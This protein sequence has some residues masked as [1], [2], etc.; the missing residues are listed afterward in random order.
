[1]ALTFTPRTGVSLLHNSRVEDTLRT[2]R[3]LELSS[4]LDLHV[5]VGVRDGDADQPALS[6]GLRGRGTILTVDPDASDAGV[7]NAIIAT[8]AEQGSQYA[9]ILR[10]DLT[11]G[12][13]TLGLLT[14]HMTRVPDCGVV[15]AR[16]M[17]AGEPRKVIWSDGATMS[18]TGSLTRASAGL[19]RSKATKAK[20]VDV[21]AVCRIGALYRVAAL[22]SVGP[23]DDDDL[24]D[25]HDVRWSE[26]ARRAGWR[27]MVQR[28][29]HP[30]LEGLDG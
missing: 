24:I 28:R 22:E 12:Q 3:L 18:A 25:N 9:W 29:A 6:D 13:W 10:P 2:L 17:Q 4:D 16:I 1:M 7:H 19:N 11:F 27:V 8:F 26:S 14:R 30:T 20:P 21:D 15:G 5:V 23:L